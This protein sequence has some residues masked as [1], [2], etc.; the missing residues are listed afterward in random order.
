MYISCIFDSKTKAVCMMEFGGES[1]EILTFVSYAQTSI[2][3]DETFCGKIGSGCNS[4]W[5]TLIR[6]C[7][8]GCF[9]E[10]NRQNEAIIKKKSQAYDEIKALKG[11]I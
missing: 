3:G 10:D 8:C 5:V 2:V 9:R 6:C 11:G 4:L 7:C 1:G